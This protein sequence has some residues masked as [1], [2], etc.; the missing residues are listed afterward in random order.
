M[1]AQLVKLSFILLVLFLVMSVPVFADNPN[2][3]GYSGPVSL[4][5]PTPSTWLTG[6]GTG[7]PF[8]GLDFI[9]GNIVPFAINLLIFLSVV[10]SFIFLVIGGIRLM[11]SGGNKEGTAKAK[12]TIMY[13][14]VGLALAIGSFL[15]LGV[16]QQL[17]GIDFNLPNWPRPTVS[18]NQLR[19]ERYL[20]CLEQNGE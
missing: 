16:V 6:L 5:L 17:F 7:L 12:N 14:L 18:C 4:S 3:P 10:L 8:G 11:I 19:G 9:V 2:G 1:R 15:I 20:R 13:A